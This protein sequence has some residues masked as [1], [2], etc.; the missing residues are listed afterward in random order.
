M[1]MLKKLTSKLGQLSIELG[2]IIVGVVLASGIIGYYYV[3][4]SKEVAKVVG[5]TANKT[6][7]NISKDV[8]KVVD[9]ISPFVGK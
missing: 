9:E 4:T 6:A 2:L 1:K 8:G 7:H 5:G 3:V